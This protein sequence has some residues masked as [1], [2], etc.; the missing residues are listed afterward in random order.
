M[1]LS[2]EYTITSLGGKRKGT[3]GGGDNKLSPCRG[4][5][6]K[7]FRGKDLISGDLLKKMYDLK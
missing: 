4:I 6:E 2:S 5:E 3:V 1:S 7:V